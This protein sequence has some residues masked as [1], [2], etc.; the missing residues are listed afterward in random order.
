MIKAIFFDLDGTLLNSQKIITQK[1][2]EI[3]KKCRNNGVKLFIATAR[4]PLLE[5][6]LAWDKDTFSLFDGGI[7]Y[8]GGCRI[9]NGLKEYQTV[10]DKI[11]QEAIRYVRKYDNL[12]IALQLTDE[13]HAFRFPLEDK[14]YKSWGIDSENAF[15]LQQAKNF[16]TVKILVFFNNLIDSV[17][18]IDDGL[19]ISLKELCEGNAQFYLTDKG[20]CVQIM[21]QAVNKAKSIERIRKSL[22]FEKT[23][24]AVFGDDYNDIEMLRECGIGIAMGNALEEV[25]A[26]ADYVCG[27]CDDNGV[28]H[29]L[30]ENLL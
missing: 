18:P 7:Y 25:K 13:Q 9:I 10:S 1:T 6:M 16:K 21:G 20:K 3:L 24:I 22:G 30:E 19:V 8:N 2:R 17:T 4:P 15:N 12:N 5:R 27:D 26:A 29:W 28:A 11:V 14:G 23:E